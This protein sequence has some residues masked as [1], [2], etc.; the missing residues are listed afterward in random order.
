MESPV[1]FDSHAH[2]FDERF[3]AQYPGGADAAIADAYAVG[4][5]Y[6]LNA[7]TS[8]ETTSLAIALAEKYSHL[9]A[10]AGIHPSDSH[11]VPDENLTAALDTIRRQCAHGKVVALGEIGLDYHWDVSQKERQKS[12]FDAQLSIAEELMLPVIIHD[13]EAHGDTVDILW[14]HPNVCGVLHS[15]SGSA[16]MARQLV[17]R[18]WYISFSGPV[19]YKNAHGVREAAAYVPIDRILIETDAPYLPPEPHRGKINYSGYL[20]FIAHA[21]AETKGVSDGEILENT[22]RNALRLFQIASAK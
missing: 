15:F 21:V 4:V 9:Y 1:I 20:P 12:I 10:S 5:R 3:A 22:T 11:D 13:R 8:P 18:G 16:E 6:I 7:G 2:Y 14:A 19:T 17:N